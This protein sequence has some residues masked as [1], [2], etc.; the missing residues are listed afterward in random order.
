M[1]ER[2]IIFLVLGA[3]VFAP[4]I[5]QWTFGGLT[6]WYGIYLPWLALVIVVSRDQWRRRPEQS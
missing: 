4:A 1:I 3:F 6:E 2:I 5:T